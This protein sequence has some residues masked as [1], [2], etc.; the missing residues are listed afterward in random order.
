[1][2]LGIKGGGEREGRES[3][4]NIYIEHMVHNY[5]FGNEKENGLGLA[6]SCCVVRKRTEMGV[7]DGSGRGGEGRRNQIPTW[8]NPEFSFTGKGQKGGYQQ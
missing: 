7:E 2:H 8:D 1:V 6:E 4:C 5:L 3:T